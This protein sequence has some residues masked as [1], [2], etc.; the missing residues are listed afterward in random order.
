VAPN[1][2]AT[3]KAWVTDPNVLKPGVQM[4]AMKLSEPE[5]DQVVA[6]LTTLH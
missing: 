3:L 5:L 2:A 6:Y 4:P 1:D